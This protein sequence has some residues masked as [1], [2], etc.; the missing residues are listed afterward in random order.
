MPTPGSFAVDGRDGRVGLVIGVVVGSV[1]GNE[2]S[3]VRLRPPGGGALWDC[4]AHALCAASPSAVLAARVRELNWQ[5]RM[6]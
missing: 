1:V 6:P 3:W 5:S 4:P 2:G